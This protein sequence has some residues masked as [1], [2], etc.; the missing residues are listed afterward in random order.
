MNETEKV[1]TE[2]EKPA[3]TNK[4][5]K[6]VCPLAF[7]ILGILWVSFGFWKAL[8]VAVLTLIGYFIGS[9]DNIEDSVKQL[10]NK[11]FPPSQKEV[12]YSAEDMEK[13]KK[14]LEK[15]EKE[16][17]EEPESDKKA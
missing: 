4:L 10:I 3:A 6:W 1:V 15:K 14:A 5:R 2:T 17:K 9:T 7:F 8:F 12:T 11:I 13:L 16:E